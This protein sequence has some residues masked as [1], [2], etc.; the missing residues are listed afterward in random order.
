MNDNKQLSLT[1]D[2]KVNPIINQPDAH[3]VSIAMSD[4]LAKAAIR[5]NDTI[6]KSDSQLL[7]K[8]EEKLNPIINQPDA[9]AVG[10]MGNGLA[11]AAIG[12]AVGAVVG[13]VAGALANKKTAQSINQTVKGVGNAVK[14]AAEGVNHTVK[15]VGNAVKGTAEGVAKGF[16]HTVKGTGDVVKGA[17]E[18]VN[19]TVKG[20]V[21]R[22][23][24]TIEDIKGSD[25]QI[26][27]LYEER[28]IADKKQVKTAEVVL[29]KHVE[30]QTAHVSV[31]VE[32]ERLVIERII[33]VD[34][35]TPVA[36]SAAD[37][38]EGEIARMEVYEETPDVH[39]QA[40]VRE[41]V[42]VRK[43]V[44]HDTVEVED[45]IRRE[46]LDLEIQGSNVIDKTKTQ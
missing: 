1:H 30:L 13:I 17:A 41:E 23:D 12:A 11:K 8:H 37:F 22:V 19:D 34:A 32:K 40:F 6:I 15:G 28:L 38:Y 29:G 43:E 45:K 35:G 46:E 16:N 21:D 33:P 25:N 2:E 4:G 20:A 39:K 44:E 36:P 31:P 24:D 3:P 18:S 9:H 42:S 10:K 5:G 7:D 14:G 27:K 26:F